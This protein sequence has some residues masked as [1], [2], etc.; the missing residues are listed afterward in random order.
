MP[1]LR[2]LQTG[3]SAPYL[4]DLFEKPETDALQSPPSPRVPL[5]SASAPNLPLPPSPPADDGMI[6][7]SSSLSIEL[8]R[9][10]G[11]P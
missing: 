3:V 2:T 6:D 1:R 4:R 10:P 11:E 8:A 5:A 9:K 7:V